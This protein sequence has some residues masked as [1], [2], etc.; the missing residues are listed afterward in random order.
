MLMNR[1]A[2]M[3]TIQETRKGLAWQMEKIWRGYGPILVAF[4]A[5]QKRCCFC[6]MSKEM[7]AANRT[8]LLSDALQHYCTLKDSKLGSVLCV[9]EEGGVEGGRLTY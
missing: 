6:S 1:H 2:N 4:V 5:C 3:L 7:S 8:D 9:Y